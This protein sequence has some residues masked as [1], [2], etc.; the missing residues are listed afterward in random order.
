MT[1]SVLLWPVIIIL[2]A[3][4]ASL[5]ALVPTG[6]FARP[7]VVL[8]FLLICPGMML[9]RFFHLR[10]PVLEWALA[11]ALSLVIDT[12]V[13]G[14]LLYAGRWSPG[15]AFALVLGLTVAGALAQELNAVLM[16]RRKAR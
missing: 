2:S 9:V 4:A 8:W 15:G 1:K 14:I 16:P 13:A 7:V 5:V 6:A 10:E 11:V 12:V 3:A